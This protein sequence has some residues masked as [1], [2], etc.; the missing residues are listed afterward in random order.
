[1]SPVECLGNVR[2]RLLGK[3]Q[4]KVASGKFRSI[5]G[6]G[7]NGE[8]GEHVEQIADRKQTASDLPLASHWVESA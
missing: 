4:R 8:S 5:F 3:R 6:C 7:E 1:M 2:F